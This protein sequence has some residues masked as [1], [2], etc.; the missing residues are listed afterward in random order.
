MRI[1]EEV[2]HAAKNPI[3]GKLAIYLDKDSF[4]PCVH[5]D[6]TLKVQLEGQIDGHWTKE[7]EM[8]Q[9]FESAM[10]MLEKIWEELKQP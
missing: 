10:P 7:I 4:C 9:F 2:V 1:I 6:V 5:V 8:E 3:G